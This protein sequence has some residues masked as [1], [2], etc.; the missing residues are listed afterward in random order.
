[1]SSERHP[2]AIEA[3]S[4]VDHGRDPAALLATMDAV[5][6]L[7]GFQEARE[8]ALQGLNLRPG[9]RVLD[10]GCGSGGALPAVLDRIS[11]GGQA[12][13][14]D[15]SETMIAEARRRWASPDR[16]L[17]FEIAD[18]R[19]LPF[20]TGS[21]DA[22]RTDR[23][24]SHVPQPEA[25]LAEMLRVTRPSGRIAVIDVDIETTIVDSPDP[26]VV[27]L[28]A[29]AGADRLQNGRIARR[30]EGMLRGAGLSNLVTRPMFARVT[31]EVLKAMF[32]DVL[33]E[34]STTRLDRA[35]VRRWWAGLAD[36]DGSGDLFALLPVIVVTGTVS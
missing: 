17:R 26:E 22:C 8:L 12:V 28:A 15:L 10:V 36:Q 4:A 7:S 31:L 19:A 18:A 24:M 2:I 20:E 27:R 21:F 11:P 23:M 14:V 6:A 32:A 30:V 34:L 35:R 25:A 29:V 1:V 9:Q 16:P 5:E 33:D 3:Y 13:G